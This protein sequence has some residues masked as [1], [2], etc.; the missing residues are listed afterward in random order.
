SVY[1]TRRN[2]G[3]K[4]AE[5]I[6]RSLGPEALK[7]IDVVIPIPE[8]ANVAA[9]AVAEYLGEELVDGFVKNCYIFRTFIMPNQNLR[10]AGVRTKLSAI[11]S[12]FKGP[13]ILLVDDS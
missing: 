11:A 4:L 1:G 10:R 12:E 13:N 3:F 6:E 5:N 2:M 7:E 8:T 9:R